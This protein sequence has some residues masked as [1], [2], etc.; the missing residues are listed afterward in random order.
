MTIT[1]QD[2]DA[3]KPGFAPCK[4][5]TKVKLKELQ[6]AAADLSALRPRGV[7][8][9]D[10]SPSPED[11]E[12]PSCTEA[13]ATF[14]VDAVLM[15]AGVRSLIKKLDARALAQMAGVLEPE[16]SLLRRIITT[17]RDAEA[18]TFQKAS[19]IWELIK[20]MYRSGLISEVYKVA[21]AS[22][23]VSDYIKF[24]AAVVLTI[25]AALASDGFI[26]VVR[27][28]EEVVSALYLGDDAW[29]AYYACFGIPVG[30]PPKAHHS[31]IVVVEAGGLKFQVLPGMG[32]GEGK[33]IKGK[34]PGTSP[35]RRL[36]C[37]G[38]M[39][40][41][42]TEDN[43]FYLWTYGNIANPAPWGEIVN[44]DAN[45][46][47]MD[48]NRMGAI[49]G[50]NLW[51]KVGLPSNGFNKSAYANPDSFSFAS[52]QSKSGVEYRTALQ[53]RFSNKLYVQEGAPE[54]PWSMY[55]DNVVSYKAAGT[56]LA[57]LD[58]QKTL[59]LAAKGT[60]SGTIYENVDSLPNVV[61][62]ALSESLLAA[63]DIHANVHV[64][65]IGWT[66]TFSQVAEN[67][68]DVKIFRSQ[69][70]ELENTIAYRN[71][72]GAWQARRPLESTWHNF[73][74]G[75]DL[76]AAGGSVAFTAPT[77]VLCFNGPID[78]LKQ[79]H[80]FKGANICTAVMYFT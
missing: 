33:A 65:G 49:V 59:H 71:Q 18:T 42:E 47:Q 32:S 24:A 8:R 30:P 40:G 23:T 69:N 29:R 61:S 80:F 38:E 43:N 19:A 21:E 17:F 11:S 55:A 34:A 56:R 36:V 7:D 35:I 54:N 62:F 26:L 77:G 64:M 5:I 79:N 58:N 72:S 66:K 10:I 57:Y 12:G 31:R 4:S 37:Y 45:R 14:A 74:V 51:V 73:G 67:A 27:I 13:L 16:A 3:M 52:F 20:V 50:N 25:G 68:V 28:A 78:D 44:G 75:G 48:T 1:Q 22:M 60:K 2:W 39:V 63:I 9:R 70:T 53:P 15:V 41:I 6:S 76:F 46:V